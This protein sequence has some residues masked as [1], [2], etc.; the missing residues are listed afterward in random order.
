M[1]RRSALA[2]LGTGC[3]GAIAGCTSVLGAGAEYDVGMAATAFVPDLL[4]VDV[5]TEVV[6][7]NNSSRGHT[8]TALDAKIPEEATYFAS[9]GFE[10][11]AAARKAFL[12][13]RN[14]T[15][16]GGGGGMLTSGEYY[17][18]TFEVPGE[19]EYV[20]LPHEQGGM[21]GIVVVEE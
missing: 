12:D 16:S 8:V 19:Y 13:W 1:D 17:R 7:Y 21:F 10:D 9:G 20:C 3:L 15:D 18:H 6:W 4:R 2:A 11:E 5:G 14:D